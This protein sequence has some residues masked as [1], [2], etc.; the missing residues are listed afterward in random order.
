MNYQIQGRNSQS[1]QLFGYRDPSI[2]N[3]M[4]AS[5]GWSHSFAPRFNNSATVTLSRNYSKVTPYFAGSSNIIG[6][7]GI[8]GPSQASINYGPPSLSF[9]N[10]GGLSDGTASVSRPQTINFTDAITY[11]IKKHH[12][13]TFGYLYR[14]LQQNTLAYPNARGSFSF[15]GLLTSQIN[16]NGQPTANTG[17]DFADFLLGLP[18]SS[19]LRLGDFNNYFRGWATS[20][21]AQDDWRATHQLSINVGIRY[22]YFS[23][24]TELYGH[25]ANLDVNPAFTQAAV[26]TPGEKGPY[27]GDLPSSLVRP[28]KNNFSPRFGFAFRPFKKKSDI[29]R[30]G[31]SIFYSGSAYE[32]IAAQMASQP[33]FAQTNNISTSTLYP[34]T[35][36]NGFPLIAAQTISNSFAIDPNYRLAYAQNWVTAVQHTLPHNLLVELE[37]HR[38]QGRTDLGVVDQPNKAAPGASLLNAANELPIAN[39]ASFNYQSAAAKLEL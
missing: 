19:S 38:H 33:P 9:T 3:G 21:Y 28:D 2:G 7:L 18:Q 37:I 8:V 14:R 20:A 25:L 1:E 30:G 12:N 39:A 11:V 5:L 4:S 23:P 15:S 29:I 31:Y 16:A 27:S 35:L 10:F 17:F 34:L 24:Y 26:V 13:M 22:E 32:Q 36:Q 6:A